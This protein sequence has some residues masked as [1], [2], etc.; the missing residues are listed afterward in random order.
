MCA[1]TRELGGS[2]ATHT[3]PGRRQEALLA[4]AAKD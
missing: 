2:L 4:V 1:L 3:S